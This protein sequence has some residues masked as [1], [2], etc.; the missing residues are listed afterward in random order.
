[1]T[2]RITYSDELETHIT[3]DPKSTPPRGIFTGFGTMR[4]LIDPKTGK[5]VKKQWGY[6]WK[7]PMFAFRSDPRYP[8][9]FWDNDGTGYQPDRH[10]TTDGGS[11]P[12]PLWLVPGLDPW[13]MPRAYPF[14][15]SAFRYGGLYVKTVSRSELGFQFKLMSRQECNA[16]LGRMA[17]AEG[18]SGFDT[19]KILLGLRIGS[20]WCWDE[21]QQAAHRKADSIIPAA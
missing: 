14:H 20:R 6:F 10:F 7:V 13:Q 15:D 11:V 19:C 1:M 3:I 4:P 16:L 2:T 12:P 17:P 21:K 9:T 5:P 18:M 8:L